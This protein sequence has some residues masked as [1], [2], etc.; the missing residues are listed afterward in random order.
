MTNNEPAE[1]Y[2]PEGK[3]F[4]FHDD[5]GH[6]P[7]Y[8]VMPD[9]AALPLNHWDDETTDIARAKWIIDACNAK[10]A[11]RHHPEPAADVVEAAAANIWL[12][13]TYTHWSRA[14]GTSAEAE[15]LKIARAALSAIPAPSGEAMA[16]MYTRGGERF[17]ELWGQPGG[18][19]E[20]DRAFNR[21]KGWTEIPLYAAPQPTPAQI[22]ADALREAAAEMD[23]QG[24]HFAS[25]RILGLIGDAQ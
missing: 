14:K 7:C 20:G 23:R 21:M 6:Q 12:N 8:V 1:L 16:S 9:G 15:Y 22:R 10:L 11:T 24:A 25:R 4:T 2:W 17:V 18:I 19:E 5:G 13:M 3:D